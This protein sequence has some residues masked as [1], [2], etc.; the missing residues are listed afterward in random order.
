MVAGEKDTMIEQ[1]LPAARMLGHVVLATPKKVGLLPPKLRTTFSGPVPVFESVNVEL[2][3]GPG[4][5]TE[6]KA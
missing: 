5:G 2:L 6:P 3:A 1:L 4:M